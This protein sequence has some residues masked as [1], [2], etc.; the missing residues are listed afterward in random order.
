M[1]KL[2]CSWLKYAK[3]VDNPMFDYVGKHH[4]AMTPGSLIESVRIHRHFLSFLCL[5]LKLDCPGEH[6]TFL[7][8]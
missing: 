5:K 1:Y 6:F 7:E 2:P 4:G 8:L 3:V